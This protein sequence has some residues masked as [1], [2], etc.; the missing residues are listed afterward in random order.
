MPT[1]RDVIFWH[2]LLYPVLAIAAVLFFPASAQSANLPISSWLKPDSPVFKTINAAVPPGTLPLYTYKDCL[3]HTKFITI[4]KNIPRGQTES[5]Y[6]TCVAQTA[7]GQVSVSDGTVRL[8][9]TGIAGAVKT[10]TGSS[11]LISPISNSKHV[12]SAAG[13]LYGANRYI[14]KDF[15]DNI[16]TA[17]QPNGSII[18]K[19]KPGV[20]ETGIKNA[21]G[22]LID[23]SD[24]RFSDNGQ[25]MIA[26]VPQRG[27]TRVNI[28]TGATLVFGAPFNYAVGTRPQFVSAISGDGRYVFVSAYNYGILKIYDLSTCIVNAN[29][30]LQANCQFKDLLGAATNR[31]SNFEG[32]Y[33][34]QFSTN[35]S[36]RLYIR[37]GGDYGYFTLTAA[38]E[39]ESQLEYLATGDSFASGEG[40][41]SYK[42]E[43]DV[44]NPSNS[45]HLSLLSYPFLLAAKTALNS[46]QSTACSGARMQDIVNANYTEELAQ[47]KGKN[48]PTED[49]NIISN[50][51]VGYRPQ[52]NF[53]EASKPANLT[54]SIGG[55][56]IGFG[57]IVVACLASGTCY[58]DP[59]QR[60]NLV[61]TI[62]QQYDQLVSTYDSLRRSASTGAHIYT[63]GYPLLAVANGNCAVNVHLNQQEIEFTNQLV[64]Y[65]NV[66][67]RQAAQ[68]AGVS[69]IDI[70]QALVGHRLCETTSSNVA[71]NGLTAGDDKTFSVAIGSN[72]TLDGYLTGHESYHPNKL[73]HQLIS[74]AIS[75]ATQNFIAPPPNPTPVPEPTQLT[76]NGLI[77]NPDPSL[78][79]RTIIFDD[80]VTDGVLPTSQPHQLHANNLQAITPA[81]LRI[82]SQ[83]SPAESATIGTYQSSAAGKIE[84]S[85]TLPSTLKPGIHLI[86]LEAKNKA[87]EDID[88]QKVVYATQNIADLDGDNTP[89]TSEACLLLPSAGKDDD[90][91]T[92]DDACDPY[93]GNSPVLS[94]PPPSEPISEYIPPLQDAEAINLLT[95]PYIAPAILSALETQHHATST[96]AIAEGSNQVLGAAATVPSLPSLT[97]LGSPVTGDTITHNH[98][99]TEESPIKIST[100]LK[101]L[102]AVFMVVTFALCLVVQVQ[103]K[104]QKR[105]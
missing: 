6:E 71:V 86:H 92:V 99:S 2:V 94:L 66:V 56:D 22:E 20:P 97:A 26:D 25:W 82:A 15:A 88:I 91:D 27:M 77:V 78:S 84:S 1:I 73:G 60:L 81:T 79:P 9:D 68:K 72:Y 28:E 57:K 40:V 104:W 18:H 69:Y 29:P 42:P 76:G 101:R 52:V 98:I 5:S 62:N 100:L 87:G 65:L 11:K 33:H 96:L 64:S 90:S 95:S 49:S 53:V 54:I 61:Y 48:N 4:P 14:I 37:Y 46:V 41:F 105:L 8:F 44:R 31:F 43:T 16:D 36:L 19:L 30:S 13:G 67:I 63:I 74:Q 83:N 17:V 7:Y 70:E 24:P 80:T 93:I 50:N 12:M 47:S 34:V 23:F 38:G 35:Y 58:S 55:N 3:P 10:S 89:N 45:C 51:L 103:K 85:F 59:Q 39:V 75:G 32:I 102:F 21:T